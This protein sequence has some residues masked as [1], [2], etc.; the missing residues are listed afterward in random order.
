LGRVKLTIRIGRE[1]RG[2]RKE[3][4]GGERVG[5]A[6][7]FSGGEG[8]SQFIWKNKREGQKKEAEG[9]GKRLRGEE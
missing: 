6:N 2:G 5:S 8:R 3:E 4:T 7:R 1:K 9:K